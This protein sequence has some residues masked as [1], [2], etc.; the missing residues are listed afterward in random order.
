VRE[1]PAGTRIRIRTSSTLSTKS[2][3]AGDPFEGSLAEAIV[4]DG[5]M[6]APRGAPVSGVVSVSDPGGKVKG[7]AKIGIRVTAVDGMAVRT[8]PVSFQA[9]SAKKRDAIAIGAT[10][11]L[12]AAIG[13]IAGGGKGA[14]IG[15]GAG[16]GAGTA[17][18][19]MT[20]GEPAVIPAESVVTFTVTG[21]K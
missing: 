7:L 5:Q 9:K 14:A 16:A 19:M 6:I 10:S 15:A 18:V 8:A 13:A 20:R 11:G 17:G 4:V 3:Q 2:A 12:G 1:I 21:L